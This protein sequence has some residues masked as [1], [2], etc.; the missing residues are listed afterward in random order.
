MHDG[1][2]APA[3]D[4]L[5]GAPR[6]RR[7]RRAARIGAGLA[8][9]AGFGGAV[10]LATLSLGRVGPDAAVAGPRFYPIGSAVGG[11]E[12]GQRAPDFVGPESH[13]GL[14][15]D[16]DG[17]PVRIADFAGKPLWIVFWA[18]WCTPCQQE[19]IDIRAAFHAHGADS[20]T[21]LAIDSQEPAASV[22]SFVLANHL[23][24]AI[25]LDPT[26]EVMDLYRARGLPAHFFV[27]GTGLVRARYFGQLTRELMEHYL[28]V[29]TGD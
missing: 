3:P 16:L 14:L 4:G 9:I 6:P 8:L 17:T 24:Y 2:S 28:G 15:V 19:A 5:G 11:I 20:L 13:A 23:D 29:I 21:V 22:R 18:T 1:R 12:I 10:Y 27:D 7:P 25:G 26:A